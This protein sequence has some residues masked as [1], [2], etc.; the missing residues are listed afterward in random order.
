MIKGD[1]AIVVDYKFGSITAKSHIRQ[2]REYMALLRQMGYRVVEGY[3]WYLSR[4]E[5]VSINE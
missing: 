1:R 5:I 3:V 4:S 2:M